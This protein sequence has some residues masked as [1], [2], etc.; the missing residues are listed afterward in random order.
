MIIGFPSVVI[1]SIW[2]NT[3]FLSMELWLL[4]INNS[5]TGAE[6]TETSELVQFAFKDV[7]KG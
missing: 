6:P 7:L 2:K 3:M 1:Y 5:I 4:A